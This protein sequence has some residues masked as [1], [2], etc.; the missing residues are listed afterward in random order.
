MLVSLP[1]KFPSKQGQLTHYGPKLSNL[2][3]FHD[4]LSENFFEIVRCDG[5]QY[6][7][8]SKVSQSSKNNLLLE[9]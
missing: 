6:I 1:K 2:I 8:K 7:D 4:L 3:M 5:V 9:Q